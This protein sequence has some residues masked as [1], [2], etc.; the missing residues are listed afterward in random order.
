LGVKVKTAKTTYLPPL[1]TVGY[2][3]ILF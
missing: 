1:R 2:H 3:Y